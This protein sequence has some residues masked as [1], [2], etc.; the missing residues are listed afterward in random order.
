M[1]EGVLTPVTLYFATVVKLSVFVF[2]VRVLYFLLGSNLFFT[3]WQPLFLFV[4]A[5][6]I[7]LGALGGL[8]QTKIKRFVGYT[9]IN[10][11]GYLLIGVSVCQLQRLKS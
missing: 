2:F 7:L 5:G 3:L 8:L 1:Y 6:S 11:M 9:S 10:Q 4:S